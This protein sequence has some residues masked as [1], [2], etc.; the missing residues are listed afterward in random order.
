MEKSH[1]PDTVPQST[2]H[3]VTLISLETLAGPQET[4]A[5]AKK[6]P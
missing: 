4:T 6:Q 1:V 2:R 5:G 3:P